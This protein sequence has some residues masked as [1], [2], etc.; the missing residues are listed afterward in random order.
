MRNVFKI[1]F[2]HDFMRILCTDL[3]ISSIQAQ[4]TR[5]AIVSYCPITD[6]NVKQRVFLLENMQ[7]Y[8]VTSFLFFVFFL[9]GTITNKNIDIYNNKSSSV[10]PAPA[11]YET[12]TNVCIVCTGQ[13]G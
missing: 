1:P 4:G 7:Q 6:S 10:H 13:P 5:N 12:R 2:Y 8:I 9:N 11:S 3:C